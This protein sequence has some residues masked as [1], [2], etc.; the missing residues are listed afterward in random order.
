[1]PVNQFKFEM[2][3]EFAKCVCV[4]MRANFFFP[5]IKTDGH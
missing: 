3:V 4:C 5:K 1:M 2:F